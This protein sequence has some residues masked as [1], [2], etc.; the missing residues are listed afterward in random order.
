MG[1]VIILANSM[2]RLVVIGIAI[3]A[4]GKV[5]GQT[6][7]TGENELEKLAWYVGGRWMMERNTADGSPMT[8]VVKFDWS[9]NKKALKYT[10]SFQS[11]GKE[12]PQYDGLYWWHPAKKQ[13]AMLQIDRRGE[14]TESLVTFDG[15]VMRQS[16][17]LTRLDGTQQQQR[18]AVARNGDN[19]FTFKASVEKNGKWIEAVAFTYHRVRD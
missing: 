12:V 10:I 1:R 13:L 11:K 3:V 14:V 2:G 15:D 16:N 9:D 8:V 17:T 18:V 7:S 5:I 4:S 6:R 19:E